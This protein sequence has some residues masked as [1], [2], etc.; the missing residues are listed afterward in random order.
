MAES[1]IRRCGPAV[2]VLVLLT[3]CR[4]DI[5]T[6]ARGILSPGANPTETVAPPVVAQTP[7]DLKVIPAPTQAALASPTKAGQAAPLAPTERSAASKASEAS[8]TLTPAPSPLPSA[9]PE[10]PRTP[11]AT[12]APQARLA[13]GR[14]LFSI[15][16][17]TAAREVLAQV[18]TGGADP[19][20]ASEARYLTALCDLR[21]EAPADAAATLTQL[22]ESAPL[23]DPFRAPAFFNLG[24][25]QAAL[26]KWNEAEAG[27]RA[28][29]QLATDLSPLVW[30]RIGAGRQTAGD[31]SGAMA[32]YTA[33][34]DGLPDLES[35]GASRRALAD[36]ALA[37]NDPLGAVQQYD[38]LRGTQTTGAWAAEMQFLAGSALAQMATPA[39]TGL[40]T[41]S[42]QEP[43]AEASIATPAPSVS[44]TIS[45]TAPAL[46]EAI[47]RWQA[48]A[49]AD[50]TSINA[51]RAIVALLD[52]GAPVDEYQ[53]GLINYF[54]GVYARAVQAF[55]RLRAVDPAG[56]NGAAWYYTGLSY[57][58]MDDT[59][60][61]L[62]ELG[63]LIGAYPESPFWADAW[64]AQASAEAKAGQTA[65]A[66]AKYR[67][68][69]ARRP[70]SPQAPVALWEAANLEA[71]TS[72]VESALA[73]YLDLG[74]RYPAADQ[75]W[76]AYQATGL[77]YFRQGNWQKAAET[78]GE[79]A[80][81]ALPDFTRPVANYWL[82]RAQ[83][84]SGQMDAAHASWQAA[85]QSS[86]MSYYGL[87]A[88][89][90]A[91]AGGVAKGMMT[92]AAG[93]IT[94]AED[95]SAAALPQP[96]MS[97]LATW[98]SGWAGEGQLDLSP[99]IL[100]DPDWRRGKELMT[101]GLRAQGLA[102]WGR[103]Q[104]RYAKDPWALASL[105]VAFRNAGAYRLSIICA[106]LVA[107]LWPGG[108]MKDAPNALQLL[109]YPLPYTDLLREEAKAQGVDPLLLAAL[110]RQES[111]FESVATSSAGA[112]GLMQVMPGTAQWIA[113]R[114]AWRNYEP[115]QAYW[116]YVNVAFGAY[117]LGQALQQF[118]GSVPSA[119]A[120]Y[121]G[122]PGNAAA[123][124]KLAP[125]DDDLMVALISF[126][127]TRVYAQTVWAQ[128]DMYRRLYGK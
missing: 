96:D 6:K 65:T 39:A 48:A 32:A 120:G 7:G 85:R 29:L 28:Y 82:G 40:V 79:M 98:M 56:R 14:N 54:N 47:V 68:L 20:E 125:D 31:L 86:P 9:T 4:P 119:L 55:D 110:V 13:D 77:A 124:H 71:E 50:P 44:A 59:A 115:R 109:A 26:G 122:G 42:A 60:R 23:T 30:R 43:T 33:A 102:A 90:W 34:L 19:S 74:R 123:W 1:A 70:A 93:A 112:Q 108:L 53:R 101:L 36:L 66:I 95:P 8:A 78:W 116:P 89:A 21:D 105:A 118:D 16:N 92:Q 100:A 12:P 127:E 104:G 62:G 49:D 35:T 76:R 83:A 69:A 5:L 87:R 106:E 103:L 45:E 121:N 61:G 107:S 63:N 22:L 27:Y 38:L 57:L 67:E 117:Y 64:M 81:A 126:G 52:A 73:A 58:A 84:A 18:L 2:M 37:Q 128:Y 25:A 114:L 72:G 46:G 94:S 75:A 11:T 3:A 113:D 99:A 97:E 91:D 51:H 24:Q 17:C 41:P 111:H 88:G 10:P 80:T 15:G